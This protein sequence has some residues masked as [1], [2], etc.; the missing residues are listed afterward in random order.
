MLKGHREI[1]IVGDVVTS[2]FE[3]SVQTTKRSFFRNA[4]E[5]RGEKKCVRR[6]WF[7]LLLCIRQI[8]RN[9]LAFSSVPKQTAFVDRISLARPCFPF[10]IQS[11]PAS[12]CYRSVS[13]FLS[14]VKYDRAKISLSVVRCFLSAVS[15]YIQCI[16]ETHSEK[17]EF[18]DFS[19]M[20]AARSLSPG[21]ASRRS[22]VL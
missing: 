11:R 2:V 21:K 4:N 12:C 6:I 10:E 3:I 15:R 18:R 8:Q 7:V 1:R 17:Y 14:R 9:V 20:F 19:E 16:C 13:L 5:S 22:S